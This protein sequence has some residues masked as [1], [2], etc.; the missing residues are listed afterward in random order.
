MKKKAQALIMALIM[1]FTTIAIPLMDT[2]SVSA[3][4]DELK[5]QFHYI[6]EDGN[7]EGWD[8][9]EDCLKDM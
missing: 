3:S 7:Y 4:E 1:L 6:R 5:I 2:V 8:V 9:C